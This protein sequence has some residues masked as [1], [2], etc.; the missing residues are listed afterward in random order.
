L[1]VFMKGTTH[2][3]P[4][5]FYVEVDA[6][7]H[8]VH[9]VEGAVPDRLQLTAGE[10]QPTIGVVHDPLVPAIASGR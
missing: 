5:G 10:N 2:R 6:A 7:V 3:W 9:V 4:P 1:I 8:G